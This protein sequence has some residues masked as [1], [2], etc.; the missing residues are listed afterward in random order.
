[1]GYIVWNIRYIPI[2][3]EICSIEIRHIHYDQL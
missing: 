2:S 1:M 3:Y